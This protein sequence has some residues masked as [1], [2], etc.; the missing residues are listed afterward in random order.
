MYKIIPEVCRAIYEV[1]QPRYL[2]FPNADEWAIIAEH[3]YRRWN[4]PHCTGALD[5]KH[6][7]VQSPPNSGS[8]FHNYK[9]FHSIVLMG[10]CDAFE[11]FIWA[12]VGSYGKLRFNAQK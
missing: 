6:Y 8:M 1:L 9:H 5:G 11:R 12:S 4:M 2:R 7:R 3:F 10:M